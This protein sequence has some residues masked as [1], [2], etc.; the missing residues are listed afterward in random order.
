MRVRARPLV[1]LALLV[2]SLLPPGAPARADD[3]VAKAYDK[4][5]PFGVVA[6]L[7]NRV[8]D[9]EQ[10]A[11]IALMREAGVQW[12]REEISWERLQPKKGGP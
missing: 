5:S 9:E 3:F 12:A 7:A 11:A 8:R 6:T 2:L 1:V 10:D 4:G